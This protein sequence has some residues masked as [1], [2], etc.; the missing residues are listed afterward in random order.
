MIGRNEWQPESI[1]AIAVAHPLEITPAKTTI[2][3]RLVGMCYS[4]EMKKMTH[5]ELL[6]ILSYDPITGQFTWLDRTY[7][8]GKK[9]GYLRAN[10][11]VAIRIYGVY[12]YA[13][14]LAWLY[15]NGRHP[16]A[17]IDHING[18]RSDNSIANLREATKTQNMRNMRK[19][20]TNTS[21]YKGV[22]WFKQTSKWR[23]CITVDRKSISLGLFHN[24]ADA[25]K[26]YADAAF[27][28]HKEF[29]RL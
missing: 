19:K 20:R 1:P 6:R 16:S 13:H 28:Y 18:N 4:P 2:I 29:A 26:A 10:G 9:A 23:A 27:K 22:Y 15:V 5:A 3:I 14:R 7:V 11:Y 8:G 17:Q 24:I 25:K 12:W 21:G